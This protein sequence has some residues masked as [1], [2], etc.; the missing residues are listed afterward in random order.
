[1]HEKAKLWT[2]A[3]ALGVNQAYEASGY[4]IGVLADGACY[5]N[6]EA[7][8]SVNEESGK[9]YYTYDIK[10]LTPILDVSA[11][12]IE[13]SAEDIKK[14]SK[15]P[16]DFVGVLMNGMEYDE[17]HFIAIRKEYKAAME[18]CVTHTDSKGNVSGW[19]WE[20]SDLGKAYAVRDKEWAERQGAAKGSANTQGS[21]ESSSGASTGS[22]KGNEVKASSSDG[23]PSDD[24]FMDA[25]DV[26]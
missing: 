24:D 4:D 13:V 10:G 14:G 15:C 8:R 25:N 2:I 7:K 12:A 21:G 23:L 22:T 9:T 11:G 5:C 16:T 3:S 1:M 26:L 6:I 20:E 19:T 17:S 18:D